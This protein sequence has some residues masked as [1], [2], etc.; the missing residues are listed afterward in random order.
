M[1]SN[2]IS[3]CRICGSKNIQNVF[4]LGNISHAGIFPKQ[5]KINVPKDY[6]NVVYCKGCSLVQLDRNFNLN[7]M[8]GK[9]YGYRSGINK[10]M[11]LHLK[12]LAEKVTKKFKLKEN[13]CVLDIASNDGTF[14]NSYNNKLI[15]VGVD[16]LIKKFINN[17]KNIN[18][19]VSNFFDEKSIKKLKIKK[20]K[21]ITALAVL[22]D[23]PK[24]NKFIKNIKKILD[25]DGIFIVEVADLRLTLK[26]NVFDTF[27]HEHLEY[28]SFKSLSNLMKRNNLKIFDHEY[29]SV[30]GGSS[31]YF[32][33]HKKSEI[34]IKNTIKKIIQIE[35]KEKVFK[36]SSLKKFFNSIKFLK[37]KF[38]F[39]INNLKKKNFIIHGYGASTK[40]NVLIQFYNINNKQLNF[41]AEKNKEKFNCFTPG[42]KIKIVSEKISRRL[43]PDYYVVFPWHFKK[44][45]LIRE[46]NIRKKGT[47]FIF[48]LPK[49]EII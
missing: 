49:I 2:K 3:T 27:C 37:N 15:R 21:L 19:K 11:T 32:I 4:S 44:E 38:N 22:Y 39:L 9:N 6:I 26:N 8:F 13:D 7:Y 30:N 10:T 14:L 16:P 45:I 36:L 1:K 41:I 42:S 29:L 43:I 28:Y 25:K 31:R 23:L 12:N 47:K 33:T 34:K 35:N 40:G 20:F 17:Y 5:K 46:K 18:Y 48:P 24:P